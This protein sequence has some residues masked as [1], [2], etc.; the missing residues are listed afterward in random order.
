M[1]Q[2]AKVEKLLGR[3]YA[4]IS[5]ARKTACGHDCENCGGCGVSG[6]QLVYA[7]AK[8]HIHAC[9]GDQVVVESSTKNVMGAVAVVYVLPFVCF[10]L[11][12]ALGAALLH[13]G[14]G[15][16]GATGAVCFALGLIPAVLYNRY[17]RRTG[18]L[19]YEIVRLF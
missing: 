14:D 11:G 2:V 13:F 9:P 10:F 17:A 6:G 12:Y 4:E 19:Q 1:T 5:V 3:E 15:M 16:S 7:V 18:A 8:N